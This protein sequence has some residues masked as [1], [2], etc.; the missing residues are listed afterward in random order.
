MAEPDHL[1]TSPEPK[2]GMI[3]NKRNTRDDRCGDCVDGD[4]LDY[5]EIRP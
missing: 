2:P 3:P 1:E 4:C 5:L